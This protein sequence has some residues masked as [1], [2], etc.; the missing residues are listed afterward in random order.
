[1]RKLLLI[2]AGLIGAG[3]LACLPARADDPIKMSVVGYAKI[4][5]G[6][7]LDTKAVANDE[8]NAY[9]EDH[10][11]QALV[12]RGFH[13]SP[14]VRRV[15]SVSAVRTGATPPPSAY[16]DPEDAQVHLNIDT[17]HEAPLAVPIGHSF[18]ISLDLYNRITG[19][20]LWRAEITDMRR[21]VD[22]YGDATDQMLERLLNAF[23]V[24]VER[25]VPD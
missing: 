22:P 8:L 11:R 25:G 1:M 23:Q 10:L 20:Y 14:D 12:K 15:F 4:P 18:R 5:Q 13:L 9:V 2:A 16:F 6:A 21:D 7:G 19:H 24:S 17:T 3:L